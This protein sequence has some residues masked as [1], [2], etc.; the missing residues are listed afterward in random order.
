MLESGVSGP[1]DPRSI[2]TSFV[3]VIARIDSAE[4]LSGV[5]MIR[6]T[7]DRR[8]VL[9]LS[10]RSL[11]RLPDHMKAVATF[12]TSRRT[13]LGVIVFKFGYWISELTKELKT[14]I[15]SLIDSIRLDQEEQTV[16]IFC[17][18]GLKFHKY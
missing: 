14:V 1:F 10:S 16:L 9:V 2:Q 3:L 7:Q 13:S 15:F 18:C 6:L 8:L 11:G 4:E 5:L 12:L 17:I